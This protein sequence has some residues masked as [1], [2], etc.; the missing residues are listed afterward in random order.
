MR[1]IHSKR[2]N[3]PQ[4]IEKKLSKTKTRQDT[5]RP[6]AGHDASWTG[7]TTAHPDIQQAAL[8]QQQHRPLA[9][10]VHHGPQ[11]KPIRA[12][13]G[14]PSPAADRTL[15]HDITPQ[16]RRPSGPVASHPVGGFSHYT[17]SCRPELYHD[18]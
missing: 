15:L 1:L 13:S 14:T 9:T 8:G 10:E 16:R 7:H 4:H 12:S 6:T 18:H 5:R 3:C 17:P 11:V 2:S